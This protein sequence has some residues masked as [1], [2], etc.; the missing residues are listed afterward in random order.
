[1]ARSNWTL[2]ALSLGGNRNTQYAG[3]PLS[4]L[5]FLL[6]FSFLRLSLFGH[7]IAPDFLSAS[8]QST[9]DGQKLL[10]RAH[11]SA[12]AL[13]QAPRRRSHD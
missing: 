9:A 4:T 8:E 10:V 7:V 3:G 6:P 1:M 12:R 2:A 13:N 5:R 11:A